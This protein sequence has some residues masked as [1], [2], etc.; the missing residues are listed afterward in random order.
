[1]TTAAQTEVSICNLA[2]SRLGAKRITALTAATVEAQRCTLHY[3]SD[4]D[5][6][7]RGHTWVFA[8]VRAALSEDTTVPAFGY[9][10]QYIL[11]SDCLRVVR[12]HHFHHSYQIEGKRLL[13][14]S[15]SAEIVYIKRIE[16]P[17][18]FD[19]MFVDAL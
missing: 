4:R 16:D 9:D 5:S 15:D 1:M 13:T 8:M 14:H 3:A 12:T 10:H 6:L 19:S 7:L 2:L 18:L 11:P 17:T